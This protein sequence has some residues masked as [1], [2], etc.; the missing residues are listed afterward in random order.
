MQWDR[1]YPQRMVVSPWV[2]IRGMHEMNSDIMLLGQQMRVIDE[3]KRS[4]WWPVVGFPWEL[5]FPSHPNFHPVKGIL[6]IPLFLPLSIPRL[7]TSSGDTIFHSALL[8]ALLCRL[9]LVCFWSKVCPYMGCKNYLTMKYWFVEQKAMSL[10]FWGI[11]LMTLLRSSMA[12]TYCDCSHM[13]SHVVIFYLPTVIIKYRSV[14]KNRQFHRQTTN[15][16]WESK[17]V[18]KS[19]LVVKP[20]DTV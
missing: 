19:Q 20:L 5:P 11:W 15:E 4:E 16:I 12:K 13:K 7:Q 3:D 14:M 18:N 8:S 17:Q 2:H 10:T 6:L 9:A 1:K